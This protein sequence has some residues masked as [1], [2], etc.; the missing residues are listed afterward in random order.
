MIMRK[1]IARWLLSRLQLCCGLSWRSIW[2][3]LDAWTRCHFM[4]IC[5]RHDAAIRGV[6]VQ[7][8]RA[9]DHE[10]LK[11][12]KEMAAEYTREIGC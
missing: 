9:D 3:V 11:F 8:V 4:A 5:H 2:C 12:E 7:E 10:L 1:R 6:S